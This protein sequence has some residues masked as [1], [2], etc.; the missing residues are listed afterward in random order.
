MTSLTPDGLLALARGFQESRVL[1][2]GAELDLFTLLSRESLPAGEIAR[3][4]GA[5]LRALSIL[6]DALAA[7]EVLEKSDDR[8]RTAPGAAC[9]SADAPDSIHPMLLH[10]AALWARWTTLTKRVG[11]TPLHER[12]A[13]ESL[14]AFIG[15]MHVVGSPQAA[16]LVAAAGASGARRLLDVG[17]GPATYTMAFLAAEPS[18]AATLFDLPPVVEIARERLEKAGLLSRVTL[19]PGDFTRDELPSGHDLAWLSAII[20]QNSPAENDALYS[21]IFQALVPGGRLVLRD[22]VMDAARTQ[23]RA[24]ALFAVN[25]LV[26][27]SGGGTYTFDEICSGLS[28]AGFTR[29]RL[30][31]SGERMDALVEA[32]RP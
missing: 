22:H 26:G 24:G 16:R 10:A 29:T 9:L 15:A 6:L 18:L 23:P 2:S 14:R 30:I 1:L 11:G 5:D 20:H 17:G 3:R 21:R 31:Q 4:L 19:V 12:A 28:R 8:Y 32:F 27:T 7:M 25:M 13:E